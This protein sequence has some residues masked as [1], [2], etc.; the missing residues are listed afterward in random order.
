MIYL[1]KNKNASDLQ[2]IYRNLIITCFFKCFQYKS[3]DK[4]YTNNA[5]GKLQCLLQS[6]I[7]QYVHYI[8]FI[9]HST[10]C[11]YTVC[12]QIFEG[13]NFCGQLK[14]RIFAILF[15]GSFQPLCSICIVIV[16]KNFVFVD[17]KLPRKTEKLCPSKI[18]MHV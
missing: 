6:V 3:N 7:T 5:R 11:L 16:L 4:T 13:C 17:D 1:C 12:M 14:S 9:L 15:Q 2:F 10:V 18:C 8:N